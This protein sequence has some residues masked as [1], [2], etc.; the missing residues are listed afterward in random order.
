MSYEKQTFAD[1]QVLTAAQLNHME[2]GIAA[3]NEDTGGEGLSDTSKTLLLTLLEN[4]AYTSPAMQAQLDALRTEW[5]VSDTDKV[6]VQS[7]SLSATHLSLKEGESATLTATVLPVNATNKNIL[8]LVTPSGYV[9]LANGKVTA[10]KAGSCT[11]SATIWGETAAAN[12]YVTVTEAE[13]AELLYDLPGETVISASGSTCLDTGVKLLEHAST[14]TPQYTI[15]LEA[16]GGDSLDGSNWPD[17]V[18]CLTETGS[19]SNLPGFNACT[20]PTDGKT[21]FAYYNYSFD[22]AIL[23]DTL[24]HA[25]TKTR[26]VIQLD[27]KKFRVGSTYC[28]LSAWKQTQATLS[29]VPQTFLVG[30]AQ[31]A[32]GTTKQQFWDGTIY[33][34]KVY[35][36]LLS[37]SKLQAFMEGN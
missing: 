29:D 34:C 22:D 32:A 17:L 35:K 37:D 7:I 3:A 8:W 1:G 11:V 16:K 23:C 24:E 26:Y 19:T 15:L 18:H 28:T 27:G 21:H 30:A 2:A 25:K 31:N 14:E 10:V 20:Y 4:A 12:C 6:P 36:G 33:Q 13:T 9:T 5:G